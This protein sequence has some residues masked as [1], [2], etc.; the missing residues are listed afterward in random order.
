M[1]QLAAAV[2]LLELLMVGPLAAHA[3]RSFVDENGT[4]HE[5]TG[6]DESTCAAVFPLVLYAENRVYSWEPALALQPLPNT[7]PQQ[8]MKRLADAGFTGVLNYGFGDQVPQTMH[9]APVMNWSRVTAYLDGLHAAGLRSVYMLNLFATHDHL[10]SSR[11]W[12]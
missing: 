11:M 12:G 5:C 10:G 4:V 2:L 1:R 3:L 7:T 6:D 8:L 9:P